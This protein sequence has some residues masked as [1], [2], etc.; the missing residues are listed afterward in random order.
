MKHHKKLIVVVVAAALLGM[1]I[2]Y[3]QPIK[4]NLSMTLCSLDGEQI[5][6]TFDVTW[7]RYLLAPTILE[8]T[9]QVNGETYYSVKNQNGRTVG[10][11]SF[12]EGLKKKIKDVREIPRFVRQEDGPMEWSSNCIR[13]SLLEKDFTQVDVVIIRDDEMTV[14]YGPAK[15]AEEAKEI[16][17]RG[18]RGD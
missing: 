1:L 4:R 12:F 2:W 14:Y 17:Y 8:G 3:L 16:A 11:L 7:H 5:D 13:L 9:I 15:T 10:E 18:I 6:V